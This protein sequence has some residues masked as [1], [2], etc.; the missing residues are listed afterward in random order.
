MAVLSALD[1][2]CNKEEVEE[3]KE[4]REREKRVYSQ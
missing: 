3:R 2:P 4:K 1:W